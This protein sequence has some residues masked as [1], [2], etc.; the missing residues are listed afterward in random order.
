MPAVQV[1]SQ[2]NSLKPQ[3]ESRY[4]NTRP[5]TTSTYLAHVE[6]VHQKVLVVASWR[7][8]Q[9]GVLPRRSRV[10]Q[11]TAVLLRQILLLDAHCVDIVS[12]RR[13]AHASTLSVH[14]AVRRLPLLFEDHVCRREVLHDRVGSQPGEAGHWRKMAEHYHARAKT[15]VHAPVRAQEFIA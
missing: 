6:V 3:R 11:Q 1:N 10:N 2:I 13:T 12:H 8:Q 14:A 7:P 9:P 15:G 5:G 4:Q